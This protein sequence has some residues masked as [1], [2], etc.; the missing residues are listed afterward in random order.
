MSTNLELVTDFKPEHHTL[1]NCLVE[2]QKYGYPKV[3]KLNKNGWF[4]A[5]EVFVTGKGVAFK[6]RSDFGLKTPTEAVSQCY[7]RLVAAMK[8]IKE[9]E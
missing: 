1:E 8:K 3:A 4:S 2:M 5:I 6:V 9:T 7:T